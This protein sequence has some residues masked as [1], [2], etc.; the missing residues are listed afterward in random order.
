[1]NL[2]AVAPVPKC[3]RE[4]VEE[5]EA[6]KKAKMAEIYQKLK[7]MG[8]QEGSSLESQGKTTLL[9]HSV[10]M[11]TENVTYQ[12]EACGMCPLSLSSVWRQAGSIAIPAISHICTTSDVEFISYMY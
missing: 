6:G 10:L 1:M 4:E 9:Q 11:L 5:V 2:C 8:L 3:C 12:N 7:P